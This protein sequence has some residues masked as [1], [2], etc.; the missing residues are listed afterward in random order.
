MSSYDVGFHSHNAFEKVL[1]EYGHTAAV[2][3]FDS[4]K[5]G[6]H[7]YAW[8]LF[9][10]AL[11]LTCRDNAT[12]FAAGQK[13]LG[14]VDD[15]NVCS[16]TQVD[17]HRSRSNTHDINIIFG[18]MMD[19]GLPCMS[20]DMCENLGN[21]LGEYGRPIP[22]KDELLRQHSTL[23]EKFSPSKFHKLVTLPVASEKWMIH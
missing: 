16:A 5:R 18:A 3:E 14:Y 23:S 7:E 11:A 4:L 22:D 20:A 13:G 10:E 8:K 15:C 19:M 21:K 1:R 9:L 6:G 17:A 2:K 12:L